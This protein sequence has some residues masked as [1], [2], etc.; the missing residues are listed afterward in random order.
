MAKW[1][2]SRFEKALV[3]R[4]NRRMLIR[5]VRFWRSTQDVL[6]RFWSGSPVT[7]FWMVLMHFAGLYRFSPSGSEPYS[8]TSWL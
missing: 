2:A 7:G 5:M 1:F 3:S 6:M 8:L 4:V